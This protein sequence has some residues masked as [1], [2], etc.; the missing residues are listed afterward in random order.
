MQS[1]SVG[2]CLRTHHSL[3]TD[4]VSD[5]QVALEL[6]TRAWR[7]A[8]ILA[9]ALLTIASS[10]LFV[11][12]QAML[13]AAAITRVAAFILLVLMTLGAEELGDKVLFRKG[14]DA[15]KCCHNGL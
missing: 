2:E 8:I 13:A 4:T 10:V 15:D 6:E 7:I 5:V 12:A 14:Q 1:S 3:R 11:D 9:L